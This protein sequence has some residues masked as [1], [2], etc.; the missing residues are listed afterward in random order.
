M[1]SA[2]KAK[3][4]A[5]KWN[6]GGLSHIRSIQPRFKLRPGKPAEFNV[7]YSESEGGLP[8]SNCHSELRLGKP[9]EFHVLR[10]KGE[11]AAYNPTKREKAGRRER[12]YGLGRLK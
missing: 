5:P 11:A 2:A 3:T 12:C 6:E 7:Q 10:S 8:Q 1:C 9:A 4:A